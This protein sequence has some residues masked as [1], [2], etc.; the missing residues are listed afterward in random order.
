MHSSE[1]CVAYLPCSRC[2]STN[3]V[4]VFDDGHGYC[5]GCAKYYAAPSIEALQGTTTKMLEQPPTVPT[6]VIEKTDGKGGILS[7][8]LSGVALQKYGITLET[9]TSG[10]ILRHYY[11]Y[12]D[13]TDRTTVVATKVR[14]V[15]DKKF[16][17]TG[18]TK[19]AGLFGL[20]AVK[21]GG[22]YLTITEGE[23]DAPSFFDLTG[24]LAV[25]VQSSS[26]A[27]RDCK[28]CYDFI[29][30]FENIILC[31]DSDEPG[32]NAAKKVARLFKA[33]KVKIMNLAP[34]KDANDWLAAGRHKEFNKLFW[35][36]E[37]FKVD[38]I[39]AGTDLWAHIS[40]ETKRKT[41]VS[42][43]FPSMTEKLYG[44]RTSEMITLTAGTGVG[45]STLVKHLALHMKHNTPKGM[46]IGL[47]M[48]EETLGESSLGLMSVTAKRPLFLPD[49]EATLSVE[50]KRKIYEDTFGDG[51]F[52]FHDHFGSTS[53]DNI[54]DKIESLVVQY[55][56]KYIILDHI[57]IIVSDQRN[58]NERQA[59]DE[60]A[61]KLKTLAVN[62]DIC[63]VVVCHLKR[64]QGGVSAE[65]G[66]KISLHDLR[67]TAGIGHL[68]NVILALERNVQ[69]E[70][71][72]ATRLKIRCLKDRLGG[73]TGIVADLEFNPDKFTY[74]EVESAVEINKFSVVA[75]GGGGE[76]KIH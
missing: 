34:L 23:L 8:R 24:Y 1:K 72:S 40:D 41:S 14:Q 4:G 45:K 36:A 38:G 66:G 20:N 26:T 76:N 2:G 52:Y 9:D 44:L 12:F 74:E 29:N 42:Y 61:T 11:P 5:F 7:R 16:F 39:V 65:E 62:R 28:A 25:S 50:A 15:K 71:G 31:F 73:R 54:L 70:D 55:D 10:R 56:C 60:I 30:S 68:S 48:L 67:G 57:S 46:N 22:M 43:P 75:G 21:P 53:I 59:L 51:R 19:R 32:M 64:T 69:A 63:L 37:P 58:P 27:E 33:N 17:Y 3:N 47:V 18:E 13:T 6:E 35:Q 49:V